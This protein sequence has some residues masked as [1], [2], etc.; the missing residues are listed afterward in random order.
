MTT[1]ET[2]Y[3]KPVSLKLTWDEIE[4]LL[5]DIAGREAY[6]A[7]HDMQDL[8]RYESMCRESNLAEA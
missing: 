4:S 5:A 1:K 7:T 6:E 3:A 8:N 2:Y